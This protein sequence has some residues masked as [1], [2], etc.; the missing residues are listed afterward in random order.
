MRMLATWGEELYS[1]VVF[2]EASATY[3]DYGISFY[4]YPGP[5][6]A[7][8]N[9]NF[10]GEPGQPDYLT[11]DKIEAGNNWQWYTHLEVCIDIIADNSPYKTEKDDEENP[12]QVKFTS[13][14]NPDVWFVLKT[15]L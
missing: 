1:V 12:S 8:Y 5:Y 15:S 10:V 14:S 3:G 7:H 2:G 13:V 11:F 6:R 9:M 4:S